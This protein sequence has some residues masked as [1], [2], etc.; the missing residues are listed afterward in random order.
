MCSAQIRF[1]CKTQIRHQ[2]ILNLRICT[3][4]HLSI[5]ITPKILPACIERKCWVH[6]LLLILSN[7][8]SRLGRPPQTS[9]SLSHHH[10]CLSVVC[11]PFNYSSYKRPDNGWT[12]HSKEGCT[13]KQEFTNESE[14]IF[15]KTDNISKHRART[16]VRHRTNKW[17]QAT[18][19]RI[20]K[21]AHA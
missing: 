19:P 9:L 18:V 6:V 7:S 11:S 13:N 3:F 10:R 4:R 15:Q 21:R 5:C 16:L 17:T 8:E 2:I 14:E 1:M 12:E 20:L